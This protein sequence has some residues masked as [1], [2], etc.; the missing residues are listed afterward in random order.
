MD[1]S[2]I[3]CT[4]NRAKQLPTLLESMTKLV[5]PSGLEWELIIV[6]NGSTDGTTQVIDSFKD[7][8]PV[9]RVFQPLAGL[10]NARNA[11]VDAASGNY[12][13]W[14][15]DDVGLD[16]Q[17]LAAY[18]EA[19]Q[20]WPNAAL[21]AG[22]ITPH[23]E[24]PTPDWLIGNADAIG[25]LLAKSDCGDVP[26]ALST[27]KRILPF[28]ANF[29]IRTA[30][31]KQFRY[32]PDLGV[33]P[34]RRMGGEE[35]DVAKRILASGRHGWWLPGPKVTHH[36]PAA[37]Q[38]L[39]YV[40]EYYETLGEYFVYESIQKGNTPLLFGVEPLLWLKLPFCFFKYRLAKMLNRK[41]WV[42]HFSSYLLRRGQ[43]RAWLAA[44]G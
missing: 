22:K 17:W 15:D 28:G 34:G 35:T 43:I 20:R 41:I 23:L 38:T 33:A 36:I 7:R 16:P 11:G 37:R 24:P 4:R 21:F 14:T 10:S 40:A 27:D 3:V 12:I 19:F 13:V 30:V 39:A 44:R 42:K 5:I 6:D 29:A 9:K 18:G 26:V 25:S 2:V 1:I 32:N 8:L 31:Q